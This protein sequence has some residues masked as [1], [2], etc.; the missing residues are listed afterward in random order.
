MLEFLSRFPLY[1]VLII[2]LICWGGIFWYLALLA[3]KVKEAEKRIA[4]SPR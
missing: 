2:V 1:S 3:K 4:G